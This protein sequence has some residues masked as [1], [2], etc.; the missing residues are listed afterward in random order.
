MSEMGTALPGYTPEDLL[1]IIDVNHLQISNDASTVVRRG[2]TLAPADIGRAADMIMEPQVKELLTSPGPGVVAI[3]GHFDRTQMGKISPLSYI[4]ACSRKL[5][6]SNLSN[7]LR[8]LD[9]A[10][11]FQCQHNPRR[12]HPL[13][14]F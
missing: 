13:T 6:D 12:E 5:C 2:H 3:D 1:I 11:Q 7:M 4:C 10:R 9:R 8:P 14:S